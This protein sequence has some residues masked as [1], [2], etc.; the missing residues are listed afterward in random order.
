MLAPR[1]AA[2][3]GGSDNQ[4]LGVSPLSPSDVKLE[5]QERSNAEPTTATANDWVVWFVALCSANLSSP[6]RGPVEGTFQE[7]TKNP[8]ATHAARSLYQSPTTPGHQGDNSRSTRKSTAVA[9]L[10]IASIGAGGTKGK[11]R[12]VLCS[13]GVCNPL[14]RCEG[15][16]R[17][18]AGLQQSVLLHPEERAL[19]L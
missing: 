6:R 14:S 8:G 10:I 18:R 7:N 2:A 17:P 16:G 4:D 15:W 1:T 11:A 19:G 5:D 3:S 13:Q 12:C 9:M